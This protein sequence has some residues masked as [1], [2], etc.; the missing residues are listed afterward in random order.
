MSPLGS[1]P[2]EH[3]E[4]DVADY[5]DTEQYVSSYN[6]CPEPLTFSVMGREYQII[7]TPLCD[8]AETISY[9]ILFATWF[10]MAIIL[11][12]TLGS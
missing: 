6:Q 5:L 10:S 11:A 8:L 2:D 1:L 4:I 9:F 7:M 3:L 12:K